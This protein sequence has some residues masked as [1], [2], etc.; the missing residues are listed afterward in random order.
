MRVL[1]VRIGAMGDV[2]HALPAVA[3]LRELRPEWEID[4]AIEPRWSGLLAAENSAT[5]TNMMRSLGTPGAGS[6]GGTRRVWGGTR[7]VGMPL[8]D[9][10]HRV[11]TREWKRVPLSRATVT[12]VLGLRRELQAGDFD[13]C[14]DMQGSIRSA[15]VGWMAAARVFAGAAEPRE[16]PAACARTSRSPSAC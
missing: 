9:R 16:R 11:A 14:V 4:W 8:V 1:I 6:G 3:A 15:M 2:L 5:P 13:V 10:W 12:S 7:G